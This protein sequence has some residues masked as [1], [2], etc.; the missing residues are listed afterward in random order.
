[1]T[2]IFVPTGRAIALPATPYEAGPLY[3]FMGERS[4]DSAVFRSCFAL[5]FAAI[6]LGIARATL[7]AFLSMAISKVPSRHQKA[8][9]DQ[10]IVQLQVG[11]AQAIFRS[12]RAFLYETVEDVWEES[13]RTGRV[14]TEQRALLRLATT[15]AIHRS[16]EAVE[17]VYHAAGVTAIAATSPFERRFRDIHTVTQQVHGRTEHYQTVG[18][19]FLGLSVEGMTL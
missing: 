5:G 15:E 9:R 19:F 2:D 18:R 3:A 17:I 6:A 10:A 16:A 11:Q 12:A 4:Q 1:V 8:L 7:E 14:S 13:C